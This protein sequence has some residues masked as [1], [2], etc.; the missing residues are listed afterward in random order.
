VPSRAKSDA[1]LNVRLPAKLKTVI[2]AA[3]AHLGQ[4]VSDYA[5]STLVQ[6][7]Q[8]VLRQ[9]DVTVLS[10]R[11]RDIFIALLEDADAKPNKA[12]MDAAKRYKKHFG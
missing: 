3:A 5:V 1:R 9:H 7:A 8:T 12:L 4:S 6:N 11:D 2:E 10:D